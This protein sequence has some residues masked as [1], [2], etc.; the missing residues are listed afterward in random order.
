MQNNIPYKSIAN[1]VEVSKDA[2]EDAIISRKSSD[3][4]LMINNNEEQTCICVISSIN[5]DNEGDVVIP[6]GADTTAF[7]KN[8][9]CL[10]AHQHSSAPIGKIVELNISEKDILIR[11]CLLC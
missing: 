8:P 11:I 1:F 4:S 10:F 3:N 6:T 2:P 5:C 9:V 7:M